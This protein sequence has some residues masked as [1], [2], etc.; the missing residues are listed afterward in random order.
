MEQLLTGEAEQG[1]ALQPEHVLDDLEVRRREAGAE[2]G[3]A[4]EHGGLLRKRVRGVV[5]DDVEHGVLVVVEGTDGLTEELGDGGD[6]SAGAVDTVLQERGV[7]GGERKFFHLRFEMRTEGAGDGTHKGGNPCAKLDMS[8]KQATKQPAR[9]QKPAAAGEPVT[10]T[11]TVTRVI[12]GE[13]LE[14]MTEQGPRLVGLANIM[15]PRFKTETTPEQQYAFEAREFLR[16][17][18]IGK[19]VKVQQRFVTKDGNKTLGLVFVKKDL[20][21]VELVREGLALVK[22]DQETEEN[23]PFLEA[24]KA[25]LAAKKNLHA[26][27]GKPMRPVTLTNEQVQKQ[28][29]GKTVPV[30]VEAMLGPTSYRVQLKTRGEF[31]VHLQNVRGVA[32]DVAEGKVM[33]EARAFAR[34]FIQHEGTVRVLP[35]DR[36]NRL[37]GTLAVEGKDVA[38]EML[39][40]GYAQI[41]DEARLTEETRAPYKKAEEAAQGEKAGLW[42]HN[43]F[44]E[45][46]AAAAEKKA[47]REASGKNIHGG[48]LIDI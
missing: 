4:R 31:I 14:V 28:Y 44:E 34:R 1:V 15:A 46:K 3:P 18:T 41:V 39:R 16:G 48:R 2:L 47:A 40:H 33:E 36:D 13:T 20:V 27:Q 45:K 12:N 29:E 35:N 25:A 30:I 32:N 22:N 26:P 24:R 19:Q 17:K 42:A 11:G 5:V 23:K 8:K 21:N 43:N 7:N 9:A 6:I 10:F 38:A 37:Y